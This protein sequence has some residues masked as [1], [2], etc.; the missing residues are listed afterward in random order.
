MQLF[1]H[2]V[3]RGRIVLEVAAD[4][5]V[6][7]LRCAAASAAGLAAERTKLVSGGR[8]LLDEDG[9]AGLQDGAK[10]FALALPEVR[11]ALARLWR[12]A[13]TRAHAQPQARSGAGSSA[14]AAGAARRA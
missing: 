8:V 14:G 2:T 10:V 1:L 7:A 3:G 12:V 13:Q 11:G 6:A 4:V 9:A 5:S